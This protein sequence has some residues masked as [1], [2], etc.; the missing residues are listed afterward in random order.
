MDRGIARS[1]PLEFRREAEPSDLPPL[2]AARLS[3]TFDPFLSSFAR[4]V[5]A[6]GGEVETGWRDGR[7]AAVLLFVRA[8][9]L[10][11]AFVRDPS[12]L[13][14]VG[15]RIAPGELY[16]EHSVPAIRETLDVFR[17]DLER[18]R[19]RH[20]LR[21]PV[22]VADRRDADALSR[23]AGPAPIE[24]RWTDALWESGETAFAAEIEG[25][26]VG[27]AW[28]GRAGAFGRVHSLYVHPRYRRLGVGADLLEAR[29][30]WLRAEGARQVVTEI[31]ID[32]A[33]SLAITRHAGGA[34]IGRMY[35]ARW[36]PGA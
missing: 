33:P 14:R 4:Q 8:E 15:S 1:A 36:E 26:I 31:A 16:V 29:L 32:N 2:G 18:A 22:R 19:P 9:R 25:T 6:V 10:G 21:H 24:R 5:I 3:A 35:R 30:R 12:D 34:P 13:D 7:L 17:F 23:L 27:A 20:P 28:G 11:S